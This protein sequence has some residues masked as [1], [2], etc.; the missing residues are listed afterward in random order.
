MAFGL[1]LYLRQRENN[2]MTLKTP[3]YS[4]TQIL[5]N[6]T[7]AAQTPRDKNYARKVGKYF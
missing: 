6:V 7:L 5:Y 3:T 4:W 1:K 2:Q